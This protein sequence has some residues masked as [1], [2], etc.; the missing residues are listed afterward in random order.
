[1][2]LF[3]KIA[4]DI[5]AEIASG[6]WPPGT[7]IPFEHE[8]MARYGCARM[9]VSKALSGL[10]ARGLITRRRKA[11]STVAAPRAAR[12]VL[13]IHDFTLEA[14]RTGR[15]YSHDILE[16]EI[17]T[18]PRAEAD[19]HGLEDG[20]RFLHIVTLHAVDG[21]PEAHEDRLIHLANVRD[22]ETESF[23]AIPPGT[24]LLRHVPWTQAEHEISA[25]TVP[26][27]I[28]R[29][30]AMEDETAGLVITRRTWHEDRL[31]TRARIIYP[32]S[33]HRLT[34]RFSAGSQGAEIG[35]DARHGADW[36][37]EL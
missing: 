19:R 35:G 8:L 27:A 22:A 28:R 13:E 11:G 24:W 37:N 36:P 5:E 26:P 25:I 9:T 30:L 7:R 32:A 21:E 15:R 2:P 6:A 4:A 31:L 29:R 10:A 23:D 14:S 17:R 33:R 12:A 3:R 16:R 34:A 20:G 1:L 18:I